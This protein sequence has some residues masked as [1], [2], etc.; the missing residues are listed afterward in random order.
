L[1][2]PYESHAHNKE[3]T[4]RHWFITL[5]IISVLNNVLSKQAITIFD[6]AARV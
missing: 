3:H 6:T 1:R 5:L 4:L 2:M